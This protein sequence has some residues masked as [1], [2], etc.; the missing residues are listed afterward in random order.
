M[1]D[2]RDTRVWDAGNERSTDITPCAVCQQPL[3]GDR[4]HRFRGEPVHSD[5]VWAGRTAGAD[6]TDCP[7]C[8]T[9]LFVQGSPSCYYRWRCQQCGHDWGDPEP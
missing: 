2:N 1:Q 3:E 6:E 4:E 9:G 5:C 7:S 8:N